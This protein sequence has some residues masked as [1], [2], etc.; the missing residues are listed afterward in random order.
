MKLVLSVL[1]LCGALLAARVG[2]AQS[3]RLFPGDMLAIRVARLPDLNRD[4]MI[5]P[6]GTIRVGGTSVMV[7]GLHLD[8]AHGAIVAALTRET[9]VEPTFVL[10]DVAEWRPVAVY[11]AGVRGGELPWRPGMTVRRALASVNTR[12]RDEGAPQLLEILEVQRAGTRILDEANRL[13]H[14]LVRIAIIETELGVQVADAGHRDGGFADALQFEAV[15]AAL[16]RVRAIETEVHALRRARFEQ[17]RENLNAQRMLLVA[18]I[19][20]LSDEL[21][22]QRRRVVLAEEQLAT[23]EQLS[24]RGLSTQDRVSNRQA[25]LMN[26]QLLLIRILS[27]RA[28]AETRLVLIDST[29][30]ELATS[31]T[32]DL[33]TELNGARNEAVA[34]R[35]ALALARRDLAAGEDVVGSIRVDGFMYSYAIHR[36][37]GN[38]IEAVMAGPDTPVLPGDVIEVIRK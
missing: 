17:Q 4:A 21:E 10:V 28:A 22:L 36:N 19:D 1:A 35:N 8:D 33:T 5:A 25:D 38:G 14:A 32:L 37:A 27:E 18:Q 13:A 34:A 2:V 30:E 24:A 7:G 31:W 12:Q 9:G 3:L 20:S 11:G 6:D 15:L 29:I 26:A 23:T 16:D